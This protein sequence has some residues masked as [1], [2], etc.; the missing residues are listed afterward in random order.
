MATLSKYSHQ[1]EAIVNFLKTRTDHPT[2]DVV[3]Q[4]LREELPNISLGT[5]YRNLNRLAEAGFILRLHTDGKT[6]HY[7]AC[8]KDHAHLLCNKC[9]CVRDIQIAPSKTLLDCAKK[10]SDFRIE[11]VTVLFTGLCM[12]CKDCATEE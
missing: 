9:G 7:D 11:D 8:T 3:Y 2:A 5:V 4:H 12:D 1:R 6:D 10:S